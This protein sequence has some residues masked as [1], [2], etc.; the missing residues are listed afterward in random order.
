MIKATEIKPRRGTKGIREGA[1][2]LN[3]VVKE[4]LPEKVTFEQRPGK[5][6]RYPEGNNSGR[7]NK[8]QRP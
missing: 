7:G 4:G 5:G 2:K 3:W 1:C 8:I 6:S